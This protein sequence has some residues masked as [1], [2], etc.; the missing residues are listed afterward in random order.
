MEIQTV[1]NHLNNALISPLSA[2]NSQTLNNKTSSTPSPSAA[3][4]P[5]THLQQAT[6]QFNNSLSTPNQQQIS[7]SNSPASSNSEIEKELQDLDL[8]SSMNSGSISLGAELNCKSNGSLSGASS[9]STQ[10]LATS[11][12]ACAGP[13]EGLK[14][15]NDSTNLTNGSQSSNGLNT[16]AVVNTAVIAAN[17]KKRISSSRTPTRKARR[18]K[19]YRNGDRFYPGIT[20][21]VSNERYRYSNLFTKKKKK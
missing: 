6:I 20:I 11:T 19:F 13:G 21:P 16:N 17:I 18:I 7:R 12:N 10:G 5:L 15:N 9:A 8:N 4:A 3:T 1:N 14:E 2:T